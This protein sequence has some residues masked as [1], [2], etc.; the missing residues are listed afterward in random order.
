M[1]VTAIREALLAF[2]VLMIARDAAAQQIEPRARAGIAERYKLR[3][4]L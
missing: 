1:I 4:R 2:L 3:Y